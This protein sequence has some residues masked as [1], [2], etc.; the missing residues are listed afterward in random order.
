[1][2]KIVQYNPITVEPFSNTDS[3]IELEPIEDLKPYIKCFWGTKESV[4]K[5]NTEYTT[6]TLI[7]P[8]T[9]VDIIYTIDYT[10]NKITAKFCGIN[11]RSFFTDNTYNNN[12]CSTFAIRFYSWSAVC[13]AEDSMR[14]TLNQLLSVKSRF[15][16]LDCKLRPQLFDIKSFEERKKLAEGLLLNYLN[17]ISEN[18]TVN[19]AI[20]EILISKGN[21]EILELSK[22]V[23]IS[24]RQLERIFNE[25]V[26]IT[27]KKFSS[28]VR[29]QYLWN[30]ILLDKNFN[31]MD[32]VSEY[33]FTDQAH[34][35][36]EFKKYHTMNISEARIMTK[37]NVDF[38]QAHDDELK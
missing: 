34:L 25:Y 35:Q 13:F 17:Q 5:D 6:S 8:D 3:H 19:N 32:A 18:S 36:H 7:I 11:D 9:C 21:V 24:S 2:K 4:R 29:Y 27:P 15:H 28:L 1:M 23:F 38:I 16:W 20:N 33:G 14:D 26:G 30:D 10:N 37:N 22:K 12:Q 31:I